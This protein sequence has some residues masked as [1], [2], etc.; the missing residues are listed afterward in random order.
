MVEC[1]AFS[2]D[3]ATLAV[4]MRDR[5]I[6]LVDVITGEK[7]YR[8]R[9]EHAARSLSFSPDG[10]TLFHSESLAR[11]ESVHLQSVKEDP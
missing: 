8:W 9:L 7:R 6:I 5:T 2:P 11:S 4:G 10:A 3:G 1:V